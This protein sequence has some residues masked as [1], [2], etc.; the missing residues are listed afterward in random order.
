MQRGSLSLRVGDVLLLA[1]DGF[2]DAIHEVELTRLVDGRLPSRDASSRP[3]V[4][5]PVPM[6][7]V[8]TMLPEVS[9]WL[10]TPTS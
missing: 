5:L 10:C 7:P 9:T 1:T 4:V 8:S 2:Y 6:K 3:M